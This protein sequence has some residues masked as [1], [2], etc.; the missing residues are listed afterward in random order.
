VVLNPKATPL[1]ARR[2]AQANTLA[3]WPFAMIVLGDERLIEHTVIQ[4]QPVTDQRA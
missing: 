1:L 3:E 2:S 4:G